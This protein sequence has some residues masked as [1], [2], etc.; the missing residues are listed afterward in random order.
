MNR[1][2]HDYKA[3]ADAIERLPPKTADYFEHGV[4]HLPDDL[5]WR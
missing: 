5:G 3:I 4:I 1:Q 2:P